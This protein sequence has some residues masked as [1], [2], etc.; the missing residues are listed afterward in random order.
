MGTVEQIDLVESILPVL[1]AQV[2]QVA[3]EASLVEISL[4]NA[5]V[6]E[7]QWGTSTNHSEFG[8]GNSN[9]AIGLPT[10]TDSTGATRS[11]FSYSTAALNKP[12][13][14]VLN[15]RALIQEKR[16]KVLANPTVIASHD[17]E[18][19]ISVVDEVVRRVTVTL[20][21]TTGTITRQVELGDVGIILDILPRVGDDGT[22]NMRIR[23]SVSTVREVTTD[24]QGNQITLLNRR[25]M[26][27][28]NVRIKDGRTLVLGGL[29]QEN[30]TL[31]HSKLPLLGDAPIVSALFRASQ[32]ASKR[33]ELVM[34]ITPHI[35]SPLKQ[36]EVH[37]AVSAQIVPE[38][39]PLQNLPPLNLSPASDVMRQGNA[40][41]QNPIEL[42][43]SVAKWQTLSQT[44]QKTALENPVQ[45]NPK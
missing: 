40:S 26:I 45:A 15:I 44:L 25:D 22:V 7:G 14:L 10:K 8:F 38:T 30:N 28:Q 37:S 6:L 31:N 33:T 9:T 2:P 18:A 34:L 41:Q 21:G 4:E 35:L 13:D 29:I 24:F 3:I 1:D 16:A 42:P 43:E 36:T 39:N 19:V 23:P 17:T 32:R 5:K 12:N 11:A 27:S 20:D